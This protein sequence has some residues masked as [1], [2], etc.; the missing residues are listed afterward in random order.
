MLGKIRSCVRLQAAGILTTAILLTVGLLIS[1]V[2]DLTTA[3]C[4]A[5]T[6]VWPEVF[7]LFGPPRS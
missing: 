6:L 7:P 2:M 3:S 5:G 4:F 1:R